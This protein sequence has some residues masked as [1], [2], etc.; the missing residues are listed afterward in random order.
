MVRISTRYDKDLKKKVFVVR[1]DESYTKTTDVTLSLGEITVGSMKGLK[2]STVTIDLYRTLGDGT[3]VVHDGDEILYQK[4]VGSETSQVTYT[5]VYLTYGVEHKLW[6]EYIS[7]DHLCLG[8]KSK[9]TTVYEET[10]PT[11]QIQ[12][13]MN[14]KSTQVNSGGSGSFNATVKI[15]ETLA[16]STVDVDVYVDDELV[17][18]LNPSDGIVTS[19]VSGLNDGKHNIRLQ[20][21][22][23]DSYLG[24]TYTYDLL[25]GYVLTVIDKPLYFVDGDNE[26]NVVR[27]RVSNYN[28]VPVTSGTCS[29]YSTTDSSNPIMTSTD[30]TDGVFTLTTTALSESCQAYAK[31]GGS[32]TEATQYN[33]YTV[34]GLTASVNPSIISQLQNTTVSATLTND[35][36]T[37]IPI[38]F[39]NVNTGEVTK[40][41]TTDGIATMTYSGVAGGDIEM[42]ATSGNQSDSVTFVDSLD[43]WLNNTNK[44]SSL[45]LMALY[46]SG[47][48][49]YAN[50]LM[51]SATSL[52]AHGRSHVGFHPTTALVN[53][54]LEFEC[55]GNPTS[56]H[57]ITFRVSD[58][59]LSQTMAI[60]GSVSAGEKIVFEMNDR[61]AT[62]KRNGSIV[63]TATIT[64]N[65]GVVS[66]R[67]V[68]VEWAF[69]SNKPSEVSANIKNIIWK[70]NGSLIQ[71]DNG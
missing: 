66:F 71:Y 32:V 27:V 62:L 56:T 50:K 29:I 51:F 54:S 30:V 16:P 45:P 40:S 1:G 2:I 31:Y 23:E 21:E 36:L 60:T 28:Y 20:V 34:Q 58:S 64:P 14:S 35:T 44:S 19:T 55:V 57:S 18:T 43:Y 69:N 4:N 48:T 46:F 53:G 67:R 26:D 10:P 11:L 61:T 24:N 25:V 13:T 33:K 17:E 38:Y 47:Y 22:D 37:G 15:G 49:E 3:V 65:S 52:D 12:F 6:V 70:S 39:T 42:T 59:Q 68:N 7:L 8:S 9:K 41:Y 5:D 63:S